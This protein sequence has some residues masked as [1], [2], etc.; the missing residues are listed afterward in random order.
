MN[1]WRKLSALASQGLL[2]IGLICGVVNS[3]QG[4]TTIDIEVE[5]QK[6]EQYRVQSQYQ[7]QGTVTILQAGDADQ[8]GN[9]AKSESLPIEVDAR[10]DYFERFVGSATNR[11]A[12]RY[13]E[14]SIANIEINKGKTESKLNDKNKLVVTRIRSNQ[15]GPF[16]SPRCMIRLRNPN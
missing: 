14:T 12:V 1:K 4:Q 15:I 3:V 5:Y 9:S 2:S 6:D 10:L 16:K 7:H 11:Q 13:Y 8:A